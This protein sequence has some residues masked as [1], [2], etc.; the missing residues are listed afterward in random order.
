MDM[1]KTLRIIA[2]LA[3]L[4][5]FEALGAAAT[6]ANLSGTLSVQKPDGTVKILSQ[7]SEVD[8]GDVLST[9][10]D[11]YARIK[12]SDGGEVTISPS[13]KLKIDAYG[14]DENAPDKDNFVFS[15]IKGGL[16]TITGLVGKRGNRDAYR[17]NTATATI[18]IRGTHFR[19]LMCQGDCGGRLQDGL[20][21]NVINGVINA[22]NNAGELNF[23]AGQFGFV[24]SLN[25][26]PILVPKDPGLPLETGHPDGGTSEGKSDT[27]GAGCYVN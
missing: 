4:L 20:H 10:K 22:R 11:S 18:G 3:A 16:R 9:E 27:G 15:L 17:L 26:Q 12:F 13:S 8:A 25:I 1:L 19:L 7:K 23:S 5:S 6:V 21:L 2:L 14:F 24:S